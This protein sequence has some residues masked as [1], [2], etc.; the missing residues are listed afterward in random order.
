MNVVHCCL[1]QTPE[2]AF[3]LRVSYMEIYNDTLT[4]LLDK[5]NG[6][7]EIRQDKVFLLFPISTV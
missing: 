4:D 5:S 1:L 7:L 6:N 2:R 3:V